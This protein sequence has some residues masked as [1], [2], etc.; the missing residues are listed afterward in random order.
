MD[1]AC[2]PARTAYQTAEA[3]R[4][5]TQA[6]ASQQLARQREPRQGAPAALCRSSRST[7]QELLGDR[8]SSRRT[9]PTNRWDSRTF[10]FGFGREDI[11]ERTRSSGGL[12]YLARDGRYSGERDLPLRSARCRC[13]IYV[14]SG[15]AERQPGSAGFCPDI[16][17]TFARMAMKTRKRLRSS[18]GGHTVGKC[19]GGAAPTT[20][21][22]NPRV[23]PSRRKASA[24]LTPTQAAKGRS[25][26]PVGWKAR[27]QQS[28][29]VGQR[30]LGNLFA[31]ATSSP[32]AP[33]VRSSGR[34]KIPRPGH[35]AGRA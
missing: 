30:V 11:W 32:E 12:G 3:A 28:G 29:A 4:R 17:E 22:R 25:R 21:V 19:H 13:L 33:P 27:G 2:R 18:S 24:G 23:A 8:S 7:A 20:S 9:S 34:P 6:S 5:G 35:G 31:Y 1:V 15:G 16:R 10:G 14:E 26:S